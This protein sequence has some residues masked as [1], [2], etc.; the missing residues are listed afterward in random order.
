MRE[1]GC[2]RCNGTLIRYKEYVHRVG[3]IVGIQCLQCGCEIEEEKLVKYP[4]HTL[5][6]DPHTASG[7]VE[8][9]G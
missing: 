2:P 5:H 8:L 3:W 7:A 1:S 4:D 9:G 6:G